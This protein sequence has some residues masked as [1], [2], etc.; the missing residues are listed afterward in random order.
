MAV[1][2]VHLAMYAVLP[3]LLFYQDEAFSFKSEGV[4]Q[5]KTGLYCCGNRLIVSA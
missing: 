5:I 2:A 4:V 3:T 1:F